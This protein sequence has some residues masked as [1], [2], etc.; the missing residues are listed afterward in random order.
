MHEF[1]GGQDGSSP[2]GGLSFDSAGNLY[3]T[4]IQGGGTC[5]P[6]SAGCGTVFEL[7][8]QAGGRWKETILHHFGVSSGDG[9]APAG[10][11][12]FDENGNLF[13]TTA[14][15]G[16]ASSDCGIYCGT[17][18]ELTPSAGKWTE[19]ILHAFQGTDGM[20]PNAGVTLNSAGDMFGTTFEGGSGQGGVVFELAPQAKAW[21]FSVL[22]QF[23][24][25]AAGIRPSVGVVLDATGNLYGATEFGGNNSSEC[26]LGSE[27]GCGV[28][29]KLS[30]TSFGTWKYTAL[31]LFTGGADG[32]FPGGFPILDTQG[33]IYGT[34]IYT[35]LTVGTGSVFEITP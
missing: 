18:F 3:G 6:S 12:A 33:N 16:S 19:K 20:S 21:H 26:R 24:S 27:N 31:Y 14:D 22:H 5:T 32:N 23:N 13:G 34:N 28:V 10:G 11:V 4:S 15:G 8:P 25:F 30:A 17:V 9:F 1:L 2:T 35:G 29:Y 7:I